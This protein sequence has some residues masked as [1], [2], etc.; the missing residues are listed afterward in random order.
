MLWSI[1]GS[2]KIEV[3]ASESLIEVDRGLI[4]ASGTPARSMVQRFRS[5]QS[6]IFEWLKPDQS[7]AT[8]TFSLVGITRALQYFNQAEK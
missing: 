2:D 3:S 5:G 7:S 4:L 6:V 8:L 1:D